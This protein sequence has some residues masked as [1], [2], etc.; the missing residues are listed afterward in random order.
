MLEDESILIVDDDI[1]L[2]EMYEQRFKAEGAMV[3]VAHDGAEA[4]TMAEENKPSLILLDLLLPRLNGFEVLET[5]KQGADT[6]EI[7]VVVLT[8]L[9]EDDKY[10]RA[11]NL[12]ANAFL[13]KSEVMPIDVVEKVKSILAEKE[14]A[15][16]LQIE[17]PNQ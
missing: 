13:V 9:L 11:K 2:L 15:D 17:S 1:V 16:A 5:L 12:G 7:P 10:T 8:V 6:K 4:I 3:M 14:K